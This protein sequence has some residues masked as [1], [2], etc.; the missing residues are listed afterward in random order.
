MDK[1]NRLLVPSEIRDA[2]SVEDR[3]GLFLIPTSKFVLAWPRTFLDAYTEQQ[4]ANPFGNL[5]FNRSFYSQMI[6]RGFD[7]TGRIVLPGEIAARFPKGE[8]A[9]VGGGRY[10][11]L[12]DPSEFQARVTPLEF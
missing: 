3:A 2:L 6:F 4:G 12:W 7:R 9:I 11:E 10:L 1:K 8:V 5:E